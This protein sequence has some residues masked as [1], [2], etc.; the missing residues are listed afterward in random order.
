MDTVGSQLRASRDSLREVVANRPMRRLFLALAG[1][2]LG[3]WA[4]SLAVAVYVYERGGPTAVGVLGVVRYLALAIVSPFTSTLAD[5]Y[6]RRRVMVLADVVQCALVLAAAALVWSDAPEVG[7]YV[8]S[9][10][11]SIAGTAFRP[12]QRAFTPSLA[13]HPGELTAANVVSSTVESVAMFA[14][15]AV[16]AALLAVADVEVVFLFDAL[17]FVWSAALV[18]GL[19]TEPSETEASVD[20]AAE[21]GTDDDDGARRGDEAVRSGFVSESLEGFRTILGNRDLRT[22]VGLYC[23]QTVV[24]GASLV[25]SV[26]VAFDLLGVS[27]ATLGVLEALIGLGGLIGGFVALVLA[28][29]GRLATDFGVGVLGWALPLV[30]VA[31]VPELAAA[32]VAMAVIGLANSIVDVNALT[33]VQRLVP[34][35]RMGRTF[36]AMES[37]LIAAMALGSLAMPLLIDAFGVR[38]AL[39]VVGGVVGAVALVGL[40]ALRR[41]DRVA[42][43]PAGLETLRAVPMFGVLPP[44]ALERLAR[45]AERVE[46]PAGSHVFVEGD[47][48]EQVYVV[49]SGRLVVTIRGEHVRTMGEGAAFG[50]IALL[51]DVPRTATVTAQTDVVLWAL[52]REPF[53]AV[54]TGHGEAAAE[55]ERTVTTLL[56]YR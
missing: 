37:A 3:D 19:R 28:Q 26:A 8:V 41:I 52:D 30:L 20:E 24:A 54:V 4:Y 44:V 11:A 14:G 47:A 43:A 23:A 13:R 39:V 6:D 29:R 2:E 32:M 42:L 17:T 22:V 36:G 40:P 49:E 31:A 15:P 51:R 9:V 34:E 18:A 16:A 46:V 50:E 12:A 1:S 35:D 5:R 56:Q 25:F 38:W 48:G 27:K 33:I 7:V 55:A 53:L 10:A 45:T 21:E